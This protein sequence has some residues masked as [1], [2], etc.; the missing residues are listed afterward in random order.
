MRNMIKENIICSQCKKNMGTN[1]TEGLQIYHDRKSRGICKECWEKNQNQ[2]GNKKILISS[3][4]ASLMMLTCGLYITISGSM[5]GL[6]SLILGIIMGII[7]VLTHQ[8][9]IPW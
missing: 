4:L 5:I 6:I 3:I 1:H 7:A 9:W 8:R 2:K